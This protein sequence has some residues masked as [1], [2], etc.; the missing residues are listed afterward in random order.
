M[1]MRALAGLAVLGAVGAVV[2]AQAPEIK[3]YLKMKQM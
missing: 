2:A 3:R 1:Q